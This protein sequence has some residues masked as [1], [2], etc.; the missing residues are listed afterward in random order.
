MK[1]YYKSAGLF[2]IVFIIVSAIFLWGR[3]WRNEVDV[4]AIIPLPATRVVVGASFATLADIASIIVGDR[5]DVYAQHSLESFAQATAHHKGPKI[6]FTTQALQDVYKPSRNDPRVVVLRNDSSQ[7]A[8]WKE[9]PLVEVSWEG[10]REIYFWLSF[11]GAQNIAQ[12]IAREIGNV[13]EINKVWYLS[14][15]YEYSISLANARREALDVL[16][17]FVYDNVALLGNSFDAFAQDLHLDVAG[18]FDVPPKEDIDEAF[19]EY[20]SKVFKKARIQLIVIDPSFPR[21]AV[22]GAFDDANVRV[23]VLDPWGA[24]SSGT[25]LE[26]LRLNVSEIL[27]GFR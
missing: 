11:S 17:P 4:D 10:G 8:E 6:F 14:N 19:L 22:Q 3:S 24:G 15:A 13:D 7:N 2:L 18:W 12:Q 5:A 1:Q 25:F 27:R 21:E 26:L 20:L 23:A 16:A 9:H